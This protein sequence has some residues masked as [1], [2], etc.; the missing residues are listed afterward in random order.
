MVLPG[1]IFTLYFAT[2]ENG[3][4]MC[5]NIYDVRLYDEEPACGMNWPPDLK[6]M[7]TY[8]RVSTRSPCDTYLLLADR[9]PQRPEVVRAIHA[10]A[11][12]QT[13]TECRGNIHHAF[14]TEHS[15]SAITVLPRVLSKIE[16]LLFAGDQD[17]ICNYVGI[18]NLIQ[19]M[20]WN[21]AT[22]LG[23][24]LLHSAVYHAELR[25]SDDRLSRLSLGRSAERL[26]EL[27]SRR[28]TSLTR[29]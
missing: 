2:R 7:Y 12:S 1:A 18:E 28:A 29:R 6:H 3:K 17:L 14:N 8:L 9:G 23:V 5:L 15:P 24:C 26:L 19:A 25:V 20:T 13:W 4:D 22:G 10:S 27:G 11:S 21:G 16:V